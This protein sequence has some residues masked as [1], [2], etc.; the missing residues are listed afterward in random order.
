MKQ[1]FQN[2][3]LFK[4]AKL[5]V[6]TGIGQMITYASAPLLSRLF[7]SQ[8]FA[9][10][11][12]FYSLIVTLAVA[13]TLRIEYLI[14][15]SKTTEEAID[16]A[17]HANFT[18]WKFTGVLAVFVVL[19][20]LA[21]G[22][23]NLFVTLIPL[24][25]VAVAQPQIFNLL[26]TKLERYNLNVSYRI[27][28]NIGVNGLSILFGYYYM[29]SN[30]LIL[31][32]LLGQ[33]ISLFFLRFGIG[34]KRVGEDV[35]N[36]KEKWL[37][38]KTHS[39]FNTTQGIIETLQLSGTIWLLNILFGGQEAGWYFMTWKLIQAPVT[40]VSNTVF[41]VQFN[42]ASEL[43]H[44]KHSYQNLILKTAGLLFGLST[45]FAICLFI[46]GPELFAWFFGKDWTMSGVFARY[47]AIYFVFNFT[48]SPFSFV[49]ILE[50]KQKTA[51]ALT[52][53]DL[54]IKLGTLLYGVHSKSIDVALIGYSIGSAVVLMIQF[55][56]YLFL[57]KP[58]R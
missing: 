7:T 5:A 50:D 22:Q 20:Y 32:F 53:F 1:F 6:A 48:V 13:S 57:S 46:W 30:G 11:G 14:P 24:G 21:I 28:T 35:S 55:G 34:A 10:F 31:G 3:Q 45:A 43:H 2:L 16:F 58:R 41:Q 42:K 23:L 33:F 38:L 49:A 56:W 54:T 51:L 18:L 19:F 15:S 8:D 39:I 26:S 40:L 44:A 4:I 52:L 36:W 17:Q 47:L 29:G 9:E 37:I 27:I 25:V 12:L